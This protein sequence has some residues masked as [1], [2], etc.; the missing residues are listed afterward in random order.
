MIW[1][2]LL[3]IVVR[4]DGPKT[5]ADLEGKIASHRER[6]TFAEMQKTNSEERLKSLRELVGKCT[7]LAPHAGL[8]VHAE[9]MYGNEWALR[10][11]SVVYQGQPLFY[12][13][14]AACR[15]KCPAIHAQ[16]GWR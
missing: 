2:V 8:V 3:V 4:P 15:R 7:I 14:D 9:V 12:L 6:R 10:Q 5:V 13:P 11:G 1:I 16:S